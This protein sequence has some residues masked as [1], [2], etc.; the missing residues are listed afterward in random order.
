MIDTYLLLWVLAAHFFADFT[1]QTQWMATNKSKNNKALGLH[2]LTYAAVMSVLLIPAGLSLT[3]VLSNAILHLL[4]DYVSSR[5]SSM[6]Y[7]DE[8]IGAFWNV[9]AADQFAHIALLILLIQ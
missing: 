7:R 1:C 4:I 6:F 2:I 8:R 3:F 5:I 9:I